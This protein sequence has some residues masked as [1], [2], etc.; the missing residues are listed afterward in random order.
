MKEFP[1]KV[2]LSQFTTAGKPQVLIYSQN[3]TYQYQGDA[4]PE[5]LMMSNGRP[6]FFVWAHM[7]GT[8]M[9]LGESAPDQ[10]W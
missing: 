1:V 10:T 8:E 3:R 6:K 7:E 4:T 9:V 5:L 2:Q